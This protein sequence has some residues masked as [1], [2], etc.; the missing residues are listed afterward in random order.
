[1]NN[2]PRGQWLTTSEA[3]AALQCSPR[4]IRRRC[5]RGEIGAR[6]VAGVWEVDAAAIGHAD[7]S[8][9]SRTPDAANRTRPDGHADTDAR[10]IGQSK[11]S[12][13]TAF[14]RAQLEAMNAALEREQSAHE[15]TRQLLA[16]ALQMASRQLPN[17]TQPPAPEHDSGDVVSNQGATN[18]TGAQRVTNGRG[19]GLALVRDGLKRLFMRK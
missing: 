18:A 13:E 15:Q 4:T 12:G 19:S 2:E 9:D 16:G 1:M 11:D 14:L 3:A 7:K 6:F 5:E 17:V 10:P 8:A